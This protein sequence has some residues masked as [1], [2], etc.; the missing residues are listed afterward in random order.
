MNAKT[1]KLVV[2]AVALVLVL[3]AVAHATGGKTRL[4]GR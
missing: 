2:A 3:F 4:V 1:W